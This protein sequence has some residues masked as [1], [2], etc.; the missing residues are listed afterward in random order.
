M[1]RERCLVLRTSGTVGGGGTKLKTLEEHL[2]EFKR[3]GFTVFPKMLS[4]TWVAEM[5]AAFEG[6]AD[7]IPTRDDSRL[8]VFVDVLEHEP[9]LVL[10]AISNERLLD[11]A[12]MLVGPHVQLESVTYRRTAPQTLIDSPATG[13][14]RDLFAFF[15]DDDVY[16]RPLLF[17]ALSYLQ[18]LTEETGP[19]RIIPGSHMRA[20]S[21]APEQTKQPHADEV[22]VYPRA[23]DVAVFHCSMLHSGS[24]NLS[25]DYRYLFFMTLNHSWLKHRA[26]F[27]GPISRA[28]IGRARARNDRRLLRLLGE[29]DLF[30]PRANSGFTQPDEEQWRKWIAEDVAARGQPQA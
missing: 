29:D 14:H 9:E 15:P 22:L 25:D 3:V 27:Q 24:L 12:E 28:V 6:I 7:R 8:A 10:P 2:E 11:F 20:Q 26:N 17:N 4:D 5:R 13:F 19:L 18:D 21:I 23:G 1:R 30:M 16:H